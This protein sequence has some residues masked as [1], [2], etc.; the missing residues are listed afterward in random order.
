MFRATLSGGG[1]VRRGHIVGGI[2]GSGGG[3]GGGGTVVSLLHFDGTSGSTTFTDETGKTWTALS[4]GPSL[5]TSQFVYGTAS[6]NNS[7]DH[8]ISTPHSSDFNFGS[9]DWTIEMWWRR[10]STTDAFPVLISKRDTTNFSPFQMLL[11]S[12]NNSLIFRC[13]TDGA[14]Y[15]SV[16][17]S[18]SS[19]WVNDTWYNASFCRVGNTIYGFHDGVS[20]GTAAI[21]GALADNTDA[22]TVGNTILGTSGMSGFIDE[23][24]I[25]KGLGRYTSNFTPTGPFPNP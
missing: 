15:G 9:G 8:G 24:R 11:V 1:K 18:S 22:L 5:G 7:N 25:T 6:L 14:T 19:L 12:S 4:A 3:G 23:L 20:I 17:T 21:S 13:S 10:G 2:G 16:I